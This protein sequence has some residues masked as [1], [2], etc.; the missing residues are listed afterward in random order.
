MTVAYEVSSH[1]VSQGRYSHA[2]ARMGSFG[3]PIDLFYLGDYK[4]TGR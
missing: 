4:Q 2:V 3:T 1:T